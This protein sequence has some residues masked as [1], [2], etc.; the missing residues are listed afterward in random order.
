MIRV[1]RWT[2]ALG[3]ALVLAAGGGI[4]QRLAHAEDHDHKGHGGDD[5]KA[6]HGGLVQELGDRHA[7]L[8][9]SDGKIAVFLSDHDGKDVAVTG[10]KA[11]ALV[12]AG[13]Q[14]QGPYTLAAA[15]DAKLQGD[16][17]APA[18]GAH[19]IVTLTDP[20]GKATQARY[21]IK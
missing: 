21:E 8:V 6:H 2:M 18:K 17:P 4:G 11:E 5:V 7:E 13:S 12:L 9:I 16:V 14:R 20:S 15:G 3:L 19:V 1:T 10:F